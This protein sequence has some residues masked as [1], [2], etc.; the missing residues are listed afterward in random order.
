M[1]KYAVIPGIPN[2]PRYFGSGAAPGDWDGD[3]VPD[4]IDNC[5]E[6]INPGQADG[7]GDFVDS[8]TT[9]PDLRETFTFECWVKPAATQ[10]R[11]ADIVTRRAWPELHEVMRPDCTVTVDLTDRAIDFMKRQ[12]KDGH[13]LAPPTL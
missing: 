9:L 4:E 13:R 11:Y 1:P 8:G 5:V 7:D 10:N 12:S 3:S 6:V 2:T